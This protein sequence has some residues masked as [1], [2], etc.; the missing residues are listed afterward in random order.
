MYFRITADTVKDGLNGMGG[1]DRETT[2]KAPGTTLKYHFRF[3]VVEVEK[4]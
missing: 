1:I 3:A 2:W 4:G